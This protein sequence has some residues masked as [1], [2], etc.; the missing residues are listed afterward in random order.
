MELFETAS[1]LKYHLTKEINPRWGA[2]DQCVAGMHLDN[3]GII[4][5]DSVYY[6]PIDN[7]YVLCGICQI[8]EM[9]KCI[10]YG[11]QAF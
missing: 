6:Q 5:I 10:N 3:V 9:N 4:I 8:I 11:K 7:E 1:G 2:Y